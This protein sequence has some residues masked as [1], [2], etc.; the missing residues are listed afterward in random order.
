[1]DMSQIKTQISNTRHDQVLY[2]NSTQ[3]YNEF[4]NVFYKHP[5]NHYIYSH[6][7]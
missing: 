5:S 2:H 3:N 6:V 7:M 1:M 4:F